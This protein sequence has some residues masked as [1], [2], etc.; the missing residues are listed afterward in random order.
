MHF[1]ANPQAKSRKEFYLEQSVGF[2]RI[3]A[4][5]WSLKVIMIT[6][7]EIIRR[8]SA[9]WE[10][11]GC[12]IHQGYDLEMGAGT[13]NPATCLRCLG[14]EPYRAAYVEPCR[15]PTD[16]RYGENPNRVQHYF[17]Y[18]VILKPSP[19]DMQQQY[20]DSLKAI[21]V[22][23]SSHDIRFVHDDWE[24]PTIGAWGLGW[25]VWMDGMEITQYTYFQSVGGLPLK[26]VTG[27]LTYG[28]ERIA[29]YLQNVDS[30]FDLKWN[31]TL[32]YG[33]IYHRNEVEFSRYNFEEASTDLWF[34]S[35]NLYEKE[36]KKLI[37]KKLPI[38]AYDFVMKASHAFNILDARGAISVT[39]RTQYIGRIRDLAK[40]IAESYVE[41]RQEQRFPLTGKFPAV[42][43]EKQELPKVSEKLLSASTGSKEHFL[44]EIGSEELP[45]T[46]VPIGLRN[47]EAAIKDLLKKE[48]LKHGE[49][50]TYGTPRRLSVIVEDLQLMIEES[51]EERRG[52][53]VDRAFNDD[54]TPSPAGIGF[55]KSIGKEQ[56]NRNGVDND[57]E[58]EIREI[59]GNG[60][61]F[62][63]VN[64]PGK[65]AA[66]IL[67]E[68][69]PGIIL[70]LEFPKKMKWADLE[71]TYARPLQ[72]IAA[73][74]GEDIV[75]FAVGDLTSGKTSKGHRQLDPSTFE[76]PNPGQY[77]ESLEKHF[78]MVD[79]TKRR[80]E[81]IKQ[82]DALEQKLGLKIIERDAVIPQVLNLVE[83]PMI[84]EGSFDEGFLKVP[85]EVLISEMVEHQKYFPI[86]DERGKLRP[87]FVITCDT[88]PTD[89]IV[90]GN[91]KVLSARLS[92]GVFLYEKD[93]DIPF[94]S[95][96]EKLKHVTYLSGLG[97]IYDKVL[98]I[99]G[100]V[101]VLQ[102]ELK[103]SSP[104]I[105]HRAA[106]LSKCDLVSDM[107]FEFPELQG[108]IG[109]YYAL[110]HGEKP[111]VAQAIEEHWMPRG[112]GAPLPV[113]DAGSILCI[114]EK[115]DNLLSCFSAGLKPTSSKDPYALRRQVL[116]LVKLVI[117]GQF[118]L[119]LRKMLDKCANH[120]DPL[121]LSSKDQVIEEVM[122]F[123]TNR[124]KSVFQDYGF[125]KDEV[126]ASI[127]HGFD[128][129]YDIFCR[130]KALHQFRESG[131]Q[132]P[133]LYEVYKRA[134]GQL[135]NHRNVSFKKELL[136]EDAEKKLDEFLTST[137][138]KFERALSNQNYDQA[139]Q[140][141][142]QM[143]P[144]LARLFD[145]VRILDEDE[146]V[147]EN[148]IALLQRVFSLFGQLLDFSK[149]QE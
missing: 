148:R 32:T 108:T 133:Q 55:L 45:A 145:E 131:E 79:P 41:N 19:Y 65:S 47:L 124:I 31:E 15:R 93:L 54:G 91:Q 84:V 67:A 149:I 87:K 53:P 86:A 23:L 20:L 107:V 71:I 140:M 122:Q 139:Y 10:E 3:D 82:L 73:M 66:D 142:A 13:M 81:I 112:E 103:I 25:E 126:E 100:H 70:N 30:M 49:I 137:K 9:Y 121:H 99:E 120:F 132:F 69:L 5:L 119:P 64:I 22:D 89:N 17:Q 147:K 118:R 111:E 90:R 26:P 141:I 146:K 135:A 88:K 8:L 16:G 43:R 4:H 68:A 62:A 34:T 123:F 117:Q 38:P 33:D 61:L 138:E 7:Q 115:I 95:F 6:F 29:M 59:K 2:G 143:Q 57:S 28:L 58:I 12:I 39:E 102:K 24:N 77:Q 27:E 51:S 116:G 94:E 35:F 96:N 18:Q 128:D 114:A 1:H 60:Y 50:M 97:T 52:P 21:G 11:K 85:Q 98:R 129:I 74:L 14:P 46:F 125:T 109:R 56:L 44:L 113:S 76:I 63:K 130:V 40:M 83:W 144:P 48:N 80:K 105:V 136:L 106:R 101:D 37:G 75:P 134:K 110:A 36:A 42:G 78:V 104:S 72:W 92:D 127:A